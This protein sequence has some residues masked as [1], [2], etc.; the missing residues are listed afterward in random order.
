M[1]L[2]SNINPQVPVGIEIRIAVLLNKLSI[3]HQESTCKAHNFVHK[4]C[5]NVTSKNNDTGERSYVG[6]ATR[7]GCIRPRV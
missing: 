2:T 5:K 1:K 7:G 4:I 3:T 6:M